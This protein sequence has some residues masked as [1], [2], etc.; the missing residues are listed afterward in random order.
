MEN[1]IIWESYEQFLR[2]FKVVCGERDNLSVEINQGLIEVLEHAQPISQRLDTA[3]KTPLI[4]AILLG[5]WCRIVDMQEE[6]PCA[7]VKFTEKPLRDTKC[8]AWWYAD[9]CSNLA[10]E[11]ILDM[12]RAVCLDCFRHYHRHSWQLTKPQSSYPNKERFDALLERI[13][14]LEGLLDT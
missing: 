6:R 3:S 1:I 5:R 4:L 8:E 12:D 14:C 10:S 2:E 13:K 11:F 7:V 9:C